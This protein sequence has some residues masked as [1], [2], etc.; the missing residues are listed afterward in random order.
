MSSYMK[1]SIYVWRHLVEFCVA[2]LYVA[3][4]SINLNQYSVVYIFM[5]LCMSY[6]RFKMRVLNS[7]AST[8][9]NSP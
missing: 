8:R 1:I 9:N 2:V 5:L 7:K 4:K 3:Q 6:T